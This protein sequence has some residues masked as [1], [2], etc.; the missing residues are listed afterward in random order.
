[1]EKIKNDPLKKKRKGYYA[2]RS[3]KTKLILLIGFMVLVL[4]VSLGVLF[5]YNAKNSLVSNIS[6]TLPQIAIQASN[7][8]QSKL[9]GHIENLQGIAVMVGEPDM[10]QAQIEK[11]LKEENEA[12]GSVW[13]GYASLDGKAYFQDG[14]SKD[15]SGEDYFNRA[16]AGES[17]I[18]DPVVAED[19]KTMTMTY[20]V[21]VKNNGTITGV[22]ISV[23]DGM[24]LSEMIKTIQFG[25]TGS[26]YM[27]NSKSE[28]IAYK[29]S[30][31][32]LNRYNSIEEAKK[33]PSL[34][35]VAEM[36]KEMIAGKTGLKTYLF[37]GVRSYGGYAPVEKEGWSI[38]VILQQEELLSELDDLKE[39]IIYAGGF[40]LLAGFLVTYLIADRFTRRMKKA[41]A[42]LKTFSAGDLTPAIDKKL[43]AHK[44]EIGNIAGS[45]KTLQKSFTSML[46]DFKRNSGSIEKNANNLERISKT[47][48]ESSKTASATIT[49]VAESISW[50]AENLMEIT[51]SLNGF[52][53]KLDQ[54][55]G[56]MD[57]INSSAVVID[58]LANDNSE[59][60]KE[61][62]RTVQDIS[63]TFGQLH[64]KIREFGGNI[65]E[66]SSIIQII[67]SIACQTNILAINASIEAARAG[68]YG[69][70][71]RVVA[72][73][74]RNLAEQTAESSK[75]ITD[76]IIQLSDGTN[77][78]TRDTDY[79]KERL[80]GQTAIIENTIGSFENIIGNMKGV[81]P[82]IESSNDS[83]SQIR[84]DKDVIFQ[85]VETASATAQEITAST[86]E[87]AGMIETVSGLAGDISGTSET[88]YDMTQSMSA[89]VKQ[90]SVNEKTEE[91]TG[92]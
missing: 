51:T 16:K 3:M 43:L 11:Y 25:T 4:D 55:A 91:Q 8:V 78:I 88:L 80:D 68:E 92:R 35:E 76:L 66:V 42:L 46:L 13:L 70:G 86:E 65:K 40:F 58:G 89:A 17:V 27:I 45:I 2:F 84:E 9:D 59:G 41:D 18:E 60:M 81:I 54:V 33:D 75:N 20:A 14:T 71:F 32:P 37:N 23:R 64:S 6:K 48:N 31:M 53:E 49:E 10:T 19:K 47:M 29:D 87:M 21:P 1:M 7:T 72:D 79:M 44:D 67:N 12:M 26:A 62:N 30:S 28:S 61:L 36:Q 52:G 24:E 74:I 34:K 39:T 77:L 63:T 56:A 82:K 73:E 69:R 5:Y 57:E 83:V 85:K 50:Q 90:F 15:I 38:T 22:L